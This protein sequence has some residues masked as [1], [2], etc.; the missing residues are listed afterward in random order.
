ME[1][2]KDDTLIKVSMCP[3]CKGMVC[4]SVMP[5]SPQRK[6]EFYKD[7]AKYDLE[8]LTITVKEY[9]TKPSVS[10]KFCECK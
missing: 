4:A 3:K 7:V 9:H 10:D 6:K 8:I 2:T 1:I 5:F